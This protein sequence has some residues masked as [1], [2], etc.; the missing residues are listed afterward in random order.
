MWFIFISISGL[1]LWLLAQSGST[2][3]DESASGAADSSIPDLTAT[4]PWLTPDTSSQADVTPP[5]PSPTPQTS[6]LQS[7]V[8]QV[9][10]AVNSAVTGGAASIVSLASAIQK[11]EGYYKG[12]KSYRNNNP[13]NLR[14]SGWETSFGA[15]GTDSTG[16]AIFDTYAH[17]FAA[18]VDLLTRRAASNPNWT[19]LDLFNSYA[20]SSDN[21]NPNQYAAFVAQQTGLDV[22]TTLGSLSA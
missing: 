11:F 1:A 3:L 12:S 5:V 14:Y 4:F 16:F 6:W 2:P 21:N 9:E 15:I 13:G 22:N 8:T 10:Y 20:P 19:L 17:G 18:L 7:A